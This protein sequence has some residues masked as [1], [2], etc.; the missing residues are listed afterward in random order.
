MK[1]NL[2]SI[3]II[4]VMFGC[5]GEKKYASNKEYVEAS[6]MMDSTASD[7]T[8]VPKI[9]KTADMRFRVKDVQQTKELL[10]ANIKAQGGTV[11]EFEIQSTVQESDKVKYSIDS[12][13]EITSFR[14]EGTLIAKV[15]AEKIDDFTNAIAKMAV[16]VDHQSLNIDDKSIAYL[17]NKLKAQNRTEAIKAI[18]Q[19]GTKKGNNVESSLYIKDD[20]IDKKIENMYIDDKVKFSTI[21]LNFYQDNTIHQLIVGNDHLKDYGPGFFKR[22][23]LNLITGWSFL[24][25]FVLGLVTLWPLFVIGIVIFLVV[26]FF[27]RRTKNQI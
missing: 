2:F 8:A 26:R 11:T 13:I 6:V 22:I 10:S 21:T 18:N 17:A 5:N 14:K 20:Y 7:T 4:V 27:I 3:A 9:V 16:F 19:A 1:K 12:L 15:P 23:G 24:K 25:E